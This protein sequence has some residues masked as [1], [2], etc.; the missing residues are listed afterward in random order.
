MASETQKPDF[1]LEY[2]TFQPE[3]LHP[4]ERIEGGAGNEFTYPIPLENLPRSLRAGN[5]SASKFTPYGLEDLTVGSWMSLARRLAEER[6]D[7][8]RK[9]FRQYM[10]L[11][12]AEEGK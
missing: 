6:R 9:Q 2:V 11:G 1:K 3:R 8:L 12:A 4:S 5:V 7:E 10:Y